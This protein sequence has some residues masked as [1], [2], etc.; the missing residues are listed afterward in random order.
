MTD[1]KPSLFYRLYM[2]MNSSKVL[3][4]I[5][6]S[7]IMLIPVLLIGSISLM[8]K[9]FPIEGY[10][11]FIDSFCNGIDCCNDDCNQ[12]CQNDDRN[13]YEFED[14]RLLFLFCGS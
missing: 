8:L 10:Q 14:F 11:N 4:C 13:E 1:K 3:L 6:S 9:S 5:R 2:G 12:R 7:L